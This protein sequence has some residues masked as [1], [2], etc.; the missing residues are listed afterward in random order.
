MLECTT[1]ST[2]P[3]QTA[4]NKICRY[5]YNTHIMPYLVSVQSSLV[6]RHL[7]VVSH[8]QSYVGPCHHGIARPRVAYRGQVLETWKVSAN[9]LNKWFWTADKGRPPAW[10]VGDGLTTPHSK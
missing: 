10:W 5:P 7:L 4:F 9:I 2:I 1:L 3:R 8:C 6:S